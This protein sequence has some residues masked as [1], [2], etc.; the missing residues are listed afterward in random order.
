[1]VLREET[2]PPLHHLITLDMLMALNRNDNK[3]DFCQLATRKVG[4][5]QLTQLGNS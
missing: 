5:L 2:T 3:L 1:M 4:T